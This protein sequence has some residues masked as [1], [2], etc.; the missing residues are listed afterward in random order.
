MLLFPILYISHSSNENYYEPAFWDSNDPGPQLEL[1]AA[2][3]LRI[4]WSS[5]GVYRCFKTEDDH[6]TYI[7]FVSPEMQLIPYCAPFFDST[8]K[9]DE[10]RLEEFAILAIERQGRFAEHYTNQFVDFLHE[11]RYVMSHLVENS[12]VRKGEANDKAQLVSKLRKLNDLVIPLDA[13]TK[14]LAYTYEGQANTHIDT[15]NIRDICYKIFVLGQYLCQSMNKSLSLKFVGESHSCALNGADVFDIVPY[16]IL[17]NAIKYSPNK[18]SVHFEVWRSE[19]S[20]YFECTSVGPELMEGE[21]FAIFQRGTRGEWARRAGF[22]GF[23][24]GLSQAE[25]IVRSA[26][27]GTIVVRQDKSKSAIEFNAVPYRM[28]T[29]R[30]VLPVRTEADLDVNIEQ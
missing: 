27:G 8:N 29:F 7:M 22:P 15:L 17:E 4:G 28:T 21:E 16:K 26:F 9:P 13:T 2:L 30:V 23:G 5:H 25:E 6:R 11:V 20:I 10:M 3:D 12:A 1:E 19:G 14:Y 18:M 24:L